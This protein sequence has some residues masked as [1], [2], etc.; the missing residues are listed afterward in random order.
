MILRSL[1]FG[2]GTVLT[3]GLIAITSEKAS[4]CSQPLPIQSCQDA[5]QRITRITDAIF[6]LKVKIKVTNNELKNN[7]DLWKCNQALLSQANCMNRVKNKK[8]FEIVSINAGHSCQSQASFR[9]DFLCSEVADT[10]IAVRRLKDRKVCEHKFLVRKNIIELNGKL[11]EAK[12]FIKRNCVKIY[13]QPQAQ[14]R[15]TFN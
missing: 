14:L 9:A 7:G 2:L 4:A 3:V 12:A 15:S 13:D 10:N 1:V 6:D 8:L 11:R 5:E